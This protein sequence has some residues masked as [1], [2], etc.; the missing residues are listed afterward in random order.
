VASG[1]ITRSTH[2]RADATPK[3]IKVGQIGTAH[4]H[5][6]GKMATLRK[7]TDDYEVVGVVEP[8]AAL[9]EAARQQATYRDLPWMT[10]EELLNTPGLQAVAVETA[11]RDLVPTAARC[12]TAGMHLHLDKPAGPSMPLFQKLLDEAA[13]KHLTVQMGYMFRNNPAF[14]FC[15]QAV[16]AGWLGEVFEMHGVISKKSPDAARRPLAEF[17]GGT[18]FELGCHLIDALVAVMGKPQRVTPFARQSRP[19]LDRL[20]DNTLAVLEYPHATCTVRSSVIEVEGDRRRQFVVCGDQGT[21]DIRPLEPPT[22]LLALDA[23]RESFRRGC[24][25]VPLPAMPG[26]YDDQLHELARIIRGEIE[27]PYPPAHDLAVHETILRASGMPC[28]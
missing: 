6:S 16:R 8:D 27:H 25:E 26:R 5:A 2:L 17:V 1:V 11:V 9:R 14:Q 18:M 7:L 15:F 20:A 28:D 23:P 12:I 10:E 24:Q 19:E 13:R 22:L 21:I 4:A 3:K